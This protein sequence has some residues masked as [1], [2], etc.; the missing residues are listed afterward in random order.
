[1]FKY[2]SLVLWSEG[3]FMSQLLNEFSQPFRIF[4]TH[5]TGRT[6]CVYRETQDLRNRGGMIR[7][8][9]EFIKTV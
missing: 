3:G 7:V 5:A 9:Y 6:V 1:M 8:L 4:P 2:A